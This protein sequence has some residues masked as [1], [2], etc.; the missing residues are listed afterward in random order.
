MN[1]II[2]VALLILFIASPVL[3]QSQSYFHEVTVELDGEWSLDSSFVVTEVEKRGGDFD[4]WYVLVPKVSSGL[5]LTGIGQ[6]RIH[7]ITKA[8]SVPSWWQLF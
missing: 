6:A 4:D 2:V 7:S 1:K 5:Q 3:S 8:Q